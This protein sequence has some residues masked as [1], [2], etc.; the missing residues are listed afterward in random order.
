M[1]DTEVDCVGPST[2]REVMRMP[3][4]LLSRYTRRGSKPTPNQKMLGMSPLRK[5]PL[6]FGTY[7][8]HVVHHHDGHTVRI[9]PLDPLYHFTDNTLLLQ[10]SVHRSHVKQVKSC[11]EIQIQ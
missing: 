4:S 1:E 5:E 9:E 8:H 6:S 11:Q 3:F 10:Y 2:G 7:S